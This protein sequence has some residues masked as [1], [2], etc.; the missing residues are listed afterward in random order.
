MLYVLAANSVKAEDTV[1]CCYDGANTQSEL[2]ACAVLDWK[3]ADE[4]MNS[5]YQAVPKKHHADAALIMD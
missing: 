3:R 2:N 5:I 1:Q 4:V